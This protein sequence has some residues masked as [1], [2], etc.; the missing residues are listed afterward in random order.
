MK[1]MVSYQWKNLADT[2]LCKWSKLTSSKLGQTDIVSFLVWWTEK[3]A[4]LFILYSYRKCISYIG[5]WRKIRQTQ[6][7]ELSTN[8]W[9]VLF[10]NM[11]WK[12]HERQR[13]SNCF[14]LKKQKILAWSGCGVGRIS[15]MNAIGVISKIWR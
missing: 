3:D 2:I 7:E 8:H 9:P 14:F 10:K 1:K 13:L 6:I 5:L 11:L 12:S 15:T 4:T